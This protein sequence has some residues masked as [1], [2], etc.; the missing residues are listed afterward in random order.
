MAERERAGRE[1]G[2]EAAGGARSTIRG[3]NRRMEEAP[4]PTAVAAAKCHW[5]RYG[6]RSSLLLLHA[7]IYQAENNGGSL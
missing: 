4:T 2:R 7:L 5:S 3:K 1:S 6:L